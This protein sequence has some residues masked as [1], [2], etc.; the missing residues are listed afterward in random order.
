MAQ[1]SCLISAIITAWAWHIHPFAD[2]NGRVA[3]LAMNAVLIQKGYMPIILHPILRSEYIA[4]ISEAQITGREAQMLGNDA[5]KEAPYMKL[6]YQGEIATQ[7][8]MLC[9]LRGTE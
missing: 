1:S 3:R 6:M 9:M 4:V 7:R 2:G 5:G 8:E